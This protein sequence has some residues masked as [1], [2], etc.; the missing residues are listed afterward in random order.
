MIQAMEDEFVS[1]T[2]KKQRGRGAAEARRDPDRSARVQLDALDLPAEL[3]A[4]VREAQ[5]I[6]S[7][8]AR[9]RQVQFIGKVMR[10]IDPE[11]VR[12]RHRR[13]RATSPRR[14]ARARSAWSNGA[15]A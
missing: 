3:L 2:K 13:D 10:R 1:R 9:R 12:A 4:A 14:R 8:E 6:T 15:S 5:R 7:H 11:P